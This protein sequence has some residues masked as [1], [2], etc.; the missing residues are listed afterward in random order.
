MADDEIA[1]LIAGAYEAVHDP[2]LWQPFVA[3]AAA[4]VNADSAMLAA[5]V[6]SQRAD[7]AVRF[8]LD[9]EAEQRWVRGFVEHDLWG[10]RGRREPVG[11]V[12]LGHH[13]VDPQEMRRSV[14]Y[15]EV[16][17]PADIDDLLAVN[18]VRT[19]DGTAFLSL[20]RGH[21]AGFFCEEDRAR[22]Q[23]VATHLGR[24]LKL[25]L[26]L[27]ELESRSEGRGA[28]LDLVPFGIASLDRHGRIL[29]A[30]RY[31]RAALAAA[32]GLSSERLA[33]RAA[34]PAD[35]AAL[36]LAVR[37]ACAGES[38]AVVRIQRRSVSR[39]W[40]LLI[41]PVSVLPE[42]SLL[43]MFARGISALVV[44][45]DPEAKQSGSIEA[46]TSLFGLTRAEAHLVAALAGGATLREHAEAAGITEG[47]ARGYLKVALQKSG[48]RR[49][50]ELVAQVLRSVASL[51]ASED[52]GA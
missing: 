16:L 8:R 38:G 7:V 28:A 49:Q 12:N 5:Y 23:L 14:I 29:D 19:S 42:A 26:R 52:T 34:A 13:L 9:S 48:A 1:A 27:H 10:D 39:P 37:R 11:R 36:E 3:D 35:R 2:E 50:S 30:N 20:Y 6:G 22:L 31:A 41:A 17:R 46:L 32:D 24:A 40:H 43:K 51:A 33:L 47:T 18:L 21:R 15:N 44:L 45:S 25:S 4:F